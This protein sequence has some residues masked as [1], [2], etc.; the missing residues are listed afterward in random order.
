MTM[1]F[2]TAPVEAARRILPDPSD[3][4]RPLV[5]VVDDEPLITETLAVILNSNG[6]AALTAPDAGEAL[7]IA[8]LMPP[9]LLIADLSMPGMNGL[10]M[11]VEMIR[12]APDCRVILF[13]G[14][15][16]ANEM[17]A[18]MLSRGHDFTWLVKPVHPA[19]LLERAFELLG[20]RGS[21][22]GLSRPSRNPSL[23]DFLSTAGRGSDVYPSS[24][25]LT[26]RQR[27]RQADGN[28]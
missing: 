3:W 8:A 11:A 13:S 14:H 15:A 27:A 21:P 7:E 6:L 17:Y 1:H 5:L 10:D 25:N 2:P 9:E 23:Y 28:G 18:Q 4:L 22:L 26:I 16:T 19:D 24:W 12:M 20:K